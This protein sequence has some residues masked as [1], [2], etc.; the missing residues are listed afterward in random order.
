VEPVA[1]PFEDAGVEDRERSV[2]PVETDVVVATDED[3]A[4][5]VPEPLDRLPPVAHVHRD[6][7]QVDE[8]VVVADR[9]VV[10]VQQRGVHLPDRGERPLAVVDDVRA[11]EVVVGDDVVSHRDALVRYGSDTDITSTGRTVNPVP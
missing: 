9:L 3:V 4:V 6:V 7:A 11:S 10:A 5:D 1:V 8:H 2:L